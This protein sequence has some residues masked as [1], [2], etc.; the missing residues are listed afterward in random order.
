MKKNHAELELSERE[1]E[2]RLSFHLDDDQ[3]RW[4]RWCIAA[5]CG[6]DEDVFCQEYP[7]QPEEAFLTSGRPVF[8]S[9]A[10]SAALIAAPPGEAG[11]LREEGGRLCFRAGEGRF[12]TLYDPPLPGAEY[13]IGCDVAAGYRGGDYSAAA[14]LSRDSLRVAACWHG[15]MEPELYG[16][17]L[18]N[19]A[20]WYNRALLIP[21]AN[22][23]GIAV[24]GE[25][26]RAGY[27]HVYRRRD[28]EPGFLTTQ[29]TKAAMI[30][31][32]AAY[33]RQDAGRIRDRE[34]IRECLS[35]VYDDKGHTNAV[36]GAHDDRVIALALAVHQL[37]ERPAGPR[38]PPIDLKEAYGVNSNTGY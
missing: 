19:L 6:G 38:I 5:N 34:T 25:L 3:L 35:Y 29:S 2:L 13:V 8:D 30:G 7:S 17:E 20:R 18:V 24:L 31:S 28:G 23:H 11:L 36:W 26:R 14:V 1:R 32:L 10:L 33:I 15:H 9:R 22:N 21:E 27:G 4:R 12:L 37:M 16:R